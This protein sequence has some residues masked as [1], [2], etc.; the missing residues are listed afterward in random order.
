MYKY[1]KIFNFY[2]DGFK[3]LTVG[4]T[5]WKI[6]IIKI[7]LIVTLLNFYIYDKSIN[8]EYKTTKEKIN[9]VYKNITKD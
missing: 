8:S 6:I 2:I 3:N 9:F 5:L 4:K 7:I 1:L